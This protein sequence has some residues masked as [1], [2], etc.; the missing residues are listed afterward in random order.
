M[1]E[2][3][4][5]GSGWRRQGKGKKKEERRWAVEKEEEEKYCGQGLN[6][7]H[8]MIEG[9]TYHYTKMTYCYVSHNIYYIILY[10]KKVVSGF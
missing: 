8:H 7:C 10:F 3:E 9:N 2:G 1:E 6:P 4:E 5:K